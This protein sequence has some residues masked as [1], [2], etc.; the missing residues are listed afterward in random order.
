MHVLLI[1]DHEM[2]RQGIKFLLTDLDDKVRFTE[3]GTCEEALAILD[4]ESI[5]LILLDLNMP[6]S[7]GLG[8]LHD[9]HLA[10]PGIPLSVL[11]G[12]D[13]P[14]VIRRAI[15]AGA[16]GFVCKASSSKVLIA[17]LRLILAGGT[18]LPRA[19]L[20]GALVST[21]PAAER[22]AGVAVEVE[23]GHLSGRQA[24]VLFKA[25]QGKPNK[26][27]ARELNIAEGTVKAHLS[28]AY[29]SLRVR[30]RTEAVY[31]AVKLGL[32]PPTAPA[33][34]TPDRS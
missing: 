10:H 6:G 31:A 20:Q 16:S 2:F 29:K 4:E 14:E 19:A 28:A 21:P 23:A 15:D 22:P 33:P 11:S 30:N 9:I 17:G 12:I 1:D 8:A 13:D 34:S 27:I 25:I 24:D 18:Y 7:D 26:I 5:D 3:A 32:K